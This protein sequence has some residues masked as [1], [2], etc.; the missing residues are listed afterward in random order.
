ML[1]EIRYRIVAIVL[2]VIEIGD[3]AVK[4]APILLVYLNIFEHCPL[5]NCIENRRVQ[6][7]AD[8]NTDLHVHYADVEDT[9]EK[10][11]YDLSGA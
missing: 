3:E 1:F 5:I 4:P 9:E 8:S 7:I 6:V 10:K 2:H 11:C